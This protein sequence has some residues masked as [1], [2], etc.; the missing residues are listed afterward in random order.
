MNSGIRRCDAISK[1]GQ[2]STWS[3]FPT[4]NLRVSP[5]ICFVIFPFRAVVRSQFAKISSWLY[6]AHPAET[7]GNSCVKRG[8][9]KAS[10]WSLLL[11]LAFASRARLRMA[12]S[13]ASDTWTHFGSGETLKALAAVLRCS[14]DAEKRRTCA[15][16]ELRRLLIGR[17]EGAGRM[18]AKLAPLSQTSSCAAYSDVDVG[19]GRSILRTRRERVYTTW[20]TR[21]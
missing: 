4:A 18:P 19:F 15:G 17:L 3:R 2:K 10:K 1:I 13:P 5:A 16:P 7:H 6:S 21:P 14:K 11:Q 20:H 8:C 12:A 9:S